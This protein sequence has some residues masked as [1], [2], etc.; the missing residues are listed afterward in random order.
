MNTLPYSLELAEPAI[1]KCPQ[2]Q[3]LVGLKCYP[4]LLYNFA[5][6]SSDKNGAFASWYKAKGEALIRCLVCAPKS[7]WPWRFG[8]R[9]K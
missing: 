5:T 3:Q 1:G 7:A 8:P 2:Y 6:R 4:L 9:F